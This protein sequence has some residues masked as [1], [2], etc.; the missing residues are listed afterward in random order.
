MLRFPGRQRNH[1]T[2]GGAGKELGLMR[3]GRVAQKM[4]SSVSGKEEPGVLGEIC[5]KGKIS[6][7]TAYL[8]TLSSLVGFERQDGIW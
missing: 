7:H 6:G 1:W 8:H 3:L 2:P 5:G 4:G